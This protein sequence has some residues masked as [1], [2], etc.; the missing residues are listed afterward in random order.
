MGAFAKILAT[1]RTALEEKPASVAPEHDKQEAVQ[2]IVAPATRHAELVASFARELKALNAHLHGPVAGKELM[3]Q[4]L[5]II[6]E[7]GARTIAIGEGVTAD[8][9][10]IANLLQHEG[11]DV[12]RAFDPAAEPPATRAGIARADLGVIEANYAIASSGSLAVVAGPSRP[13]SLTLIPPASLVIIRTDR[14]LADMAA[15]IEALGAANFIDHRVAIIT[16]PSRT[17]DIEKRI[18]LGVHGPKELHVLAVW[19]G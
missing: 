6:D 13:N 3:R 11:R 8:A 15:V 14:I 9:A 17:A 16:G 19:P 4:A 5:A 1:V 18:V 10:A 2:A 12:V 7:I